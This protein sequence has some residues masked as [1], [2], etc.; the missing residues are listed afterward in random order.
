MSAPIPKDLASNSFVRVLLCALLVPALLPATILPDAIGDW[1]KAKSSAPAL[2]DQAVWTEYGL[3]DSE[4]AAYEKGA[5]KVSVTAYQMQDSTGAFSVFEWQRAANATASKAATYAAETPTSLLLVHGNYL[6]NFDGTK[7]VPA[8]LEALYGQLKNVDGTPFPSLPRHLP[9]TDLVA[10]SERYVTGPVTLQQFFPQAP[11]SVA[12]FHYGSEAQTGVF[13]SPK[14][15]LKLAVF[16]YPTPQI[17][18]QR[19]NAYQGIPG[20]L[21]KRTGP[22]IAV[23]V[24][25]PDADEAERLL[26]QVTYRAE[27]TMNEHIATRKDNIGNLVVN[28]FV[29]AGILL[30]ICLAGGLA[31]GGIR[32]LRRRGKDNPD[33]DAVISLHLE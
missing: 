21:A 28:A 22:L 25:P 11:P 32:L 33:A 10:N 27:I 3:R 17:A 31:M 13:H 4:T 2:T 14:G 15:D 8:D 30:A 20:A 1:H 9:S 18:M 24:A 16:E 12:A 6:L 5:E 19:L 26:A 23:T 29:L 7:P